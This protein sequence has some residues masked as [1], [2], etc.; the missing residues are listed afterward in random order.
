MSCR[1]RTG[2]QHQNE[3]SAV[4]LTNFSQRRRLSHALFC[5]CLFLPRL[6]SSLALYS[7]P[8]LDLT[9]LLLKTCPPPLPLPSHSCSHPSFSLSPPRLLPFT[10]CLTVLCLI[11][12]RTV[13]GRSRIPTLMIYTT[14]CSYTYHLPRHRLIPLPHLLLRPRLRLP[15]LAS[16]S[17]PAHDVHHTTPP[18]PLPQHHHQQQRRRRHAVYQATHAKTPTHQV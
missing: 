2:L 17:P 1:I 12:L 13:R 3:P 8:D 15:Q 16:P 11:F 10:I 14:V 9:G 5:H 7:L 4:P 18:P 6:S